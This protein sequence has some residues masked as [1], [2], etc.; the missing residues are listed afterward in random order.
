L[1]ASRRP[2]LLVALRTVLR[3]GGEYKNLADDQLVDVFDA[4]PR[5]T[6]LNLLSIAMKEL[7]IGWPNEQWLPVRNPIFTLMDAKDVA[8]S[9]GHFRRKH[10]LTIHIE[11]E[12]LRTSQ[13][14]EHGWL[15]RQKSELPTA[16]LAAPHPTPPVARE[17]AV[18][19]VAQP[20]IKEDTA[21]RY[22]HGIGVEKDHPRALRMFLD[23]AAKGDKIAMNNI[24][25]I[26]KC[27]YGVV[28]DYAEAMRWFRKAADVLEVANSNIAKLYAEGLG[29]TV[30]RVS[31]FLWFARAIRLGSTS[32]IQEQ[33]QLT[34]K[35]TPAELAQI[36]QNLDYDPL[37]QA[38]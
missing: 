32:A 12:P 2:G 35:L 33:A 30:D 1:P 3:R 22:L 24:G 5:V 17:I 19:V 25:V 6:Q 7:G 23:E 28:V 8:V 13:W 37:S 36:S 21:I 10:G 18:Q 14:L 11:A 27:G 29:V 34:A 20:E 16:P 31:A 9:A 15:V 26:Y 38:G 4:F